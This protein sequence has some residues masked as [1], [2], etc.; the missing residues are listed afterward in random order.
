[1]KILL[2]AMLALTA[3]AVRAENNRNYQQQGNRFVV[4]TDGSTH[5]QTQDGFE[6]GYSGGNQQQ[7]QRQGFNDVETGRRYEPIGDNGYINTES[8]QYMNGE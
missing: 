6:Y 2:F 1:M 8:G 5:W 7:G 4:G 3:L